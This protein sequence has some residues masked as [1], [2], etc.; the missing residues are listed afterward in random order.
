MGP[1]CTAD[2][3]RGTSRA[4]ASAAS[5]AASGSTLVYVSAVIAI[6]ACPSISD[7]TLTFAPLQALLELADPVPASSAG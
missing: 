7:T 3:R 1:G 6:V 4:A 2:V 5:R